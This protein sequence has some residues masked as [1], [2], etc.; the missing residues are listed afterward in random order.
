MP[1]WLI[2][3]AVQRAISWLPASHVFN[4]LF[5]R[6]VTHSLDLAPSRFELRLQHCA[7]HLRNFLENSPSR[8]SAFS[9]VEIGTGWYPVVPIG[10]FLCG[11]FDVWTFDISPLIDTGRL[12]ATLDMFL[13][14]ADSGKLAE[15][16]PG[17][18]PDRLKLFRETM[19][20]PLAAPPSEALE[21]LKIHLRI[22][23]AQD[24]QLPA[25]SV[26]LF[27]SSGVLE[28]IPRPVLRGMLREFKRVGKERAIQSHY[29]NLVDQFSYFDHSITPFNMLQYSDKTWKW[30]NSPLTWQN[31][32]RIS[33]YRRLFAEEGFEITKE[34]NTPGFASDLEKIRLAPE[35]QH[36]PVEDLLVLLSW[37][38]ARPKA[39]FK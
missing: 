34:E 2:K 25:G 1:H 37:M 19:A 24:T 23:D 4:S 3:S 33:D 21:K 20:G 12:R 13:Q 11:A 32:L 38:V 8:P 14:Y 15:F 28:Y 22:R 7:R 5:Q 29:L 35:F 16:L 18:R 9:V 10:L 17:V 39:G 30:L 6:H 36:Y 31:R 26:D 27:L